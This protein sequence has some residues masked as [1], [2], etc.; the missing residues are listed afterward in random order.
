M[1]AGIE[2]CCEEREESW[3]RN[4]VA[5][6]TSHIEKDGKTLHRSSTFGDEHQRGSCVHIR[7]L[8]GMHGVHLVAARSLLRIPHQKRARQRM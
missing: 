2:R 7:L 6:A 4:V 8:L 3:L 1:K 5:E